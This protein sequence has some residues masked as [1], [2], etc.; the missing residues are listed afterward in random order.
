MAYH[1]FKEIY[2]KLQKNNNCVWPV[3]RFPKVNAHTR[4]IHHYIVQTNPYEAA[5]LRK[6][7][8]GHLKGVGLSVGDARRT[9]KYFLPSS[10]LLS[11]HGITSRQPCFNVSIRRPLENFRESCLLSPFPKQG[12]LI[13][14][15]DYTLLTATLFTQAKGKPSEA[16]ARVWWWGEWGLE[17]ERARR[18]S[19]SPP[20]TQSNLPFCAGV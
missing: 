20:S 14:Y 8:G 7:G 19:R 3:V 12:N 11:Q 9:L 13:N 10:Y 17:A 4:Y 5:T 18:I 2:I 16:N 1:G 15:V 6:T